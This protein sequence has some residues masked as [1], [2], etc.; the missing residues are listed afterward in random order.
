MIKTLLW[1]RCLAQLISVSVLFIL[2]GFSSVPVFAQEWESTDSMITQR[3]IHA[4]VLL[5]SGRVLAAGGRDYG[6]PLTAAEI[7][8]PAEPDGQ[9]WSFAAPLPTPHRRHGILLSTGKVLIVG[10]DPEPATAYLFD[11]NAGPQGAWTS[12]GN[13][14][15][16]ARY[17]AKL[18]ELPDGK[19][20]YS[21][22]YGGGSG[23]P[24]FSSAELYDPLTNIWSLTGSMALQR[25]SYTA[26]LLTVGPNAGKVLVA[27]GGIR[28]GLITHSSAEIY[29]PVTG[30]WAPAATMNSLRK[31]HTATLLPDGRVLV[32][33]GFI[34]PSSA[35][36]A[37]AEIYDPVNDTWTPAASMTTARA[38]HTAT[39]LLDGR[40]L[41][42]GGA[43]T[44]WSLVVG[45]A[46]IFDPVTEQWLDAGSMATPRVF[47][48]ATLLPSGEVLMTGGSN[49][50]SNAMASNEIFTP[51]VCVPPYSGL[52]SW[53]TL[54]ETSGP[55]AADIA[56]GND[57]T[58]V[59]GP[60]PASGMVDGALS[61]DGVDDVVRTPLIND[62]TNGITFSVWVKTTTTDLYDVIITNG[63][64]INSDEA[65]MGLLLNQGRVALGSGTGVH[66]VNNFAIYGPK[67]NDGLFHYVSGTWTGDTT[68][69]GANLYVD[70][71]LVGTA[72]A[73]ASVATSSPRGTDIGA[74]A[75]TTGTGAGLNLYNL[76]GLIDEVQIFNRVLTALEIEDVFSTEQCKTDLDGDGLIADNC[77]LIFNPSQADND[78]DGIGDVCD[79]DDD[80]DGTLDTSDNCPMVSNPDQTDNDLD[81]AGD[82]CDDDDDN[83]SVLDV[84]DNCPFNANIDQSDIDGDTLGDV[85]DDDPDGDGVIAGD[86]CP[87]N[88]NP[89]QE[90]NDSD[91]SG[92]ACDEDDDNDGV[93][94]TAD[95]CPTVANTNQ[96]DLDTDNIGDACDIDIDG[97]GV[98]NDLDNC[99]FIANIGQEDTD[100]DGEGDG[101]DADD[102]NDSI[103]DV[104]DN[105][106]L[107]VN[108]DQSDF[109]GDGQ[110]DVCDGDLDGDGVGNDVDNCISV[111][112]A[113]QYDWNNDGEGDVCD[114][115]VDGDGIV[116]GSDQC[117]FTQL[118]DIVDP[119][120]GCSIDQ[121]NPCDHPQGQSTPWKNHGQYVSSVTHTANSF[122]QQGLITQAERNIIVSNAANSTCGNK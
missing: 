18:I 72:T 16:L 25:V 118:G 51:S 91:G 1:R 90:D 37:T 12:T 80:N 60:I 89:L 32:S 114:D 59:N 122:V 99:P 78:A 9:K 56:G 106:P 86:N 23:S 76:E 3:Y 63:G 5:P 109:D 103:L 116:N 21:G 47:H 108:S 58:H 77:P 111:A 68:V 113:N 61:F 50:G 57:G 70:G 73:N 2:I 40:V 44:A 29:D 48:A 20:L 94:D 87:L 49:N 62:Y 27:G 31:Q 98:E 26:T 82:V 79:P 107:I 19:I 39:R 64:G 121:L 92:D 46:E 7:Y 117:E 22:G 13:Q 52:V 95:N 36:T 55:V 8:D 17:G 112:N 97:D 88:P 84:N 85:C 30:T 93:P 104:N 101:C 71:V 45:T 15:S 53:W 105:C 28:A 24:T 81:N 102:D 119:S 43:Q 65:G 74:Y 4:A 120:N 66:G 33:G 10:E 38:A 35:T 42:A 67:I 14:P 110:G 6:P 83:D 11:E 54:D 75:P 115:D 96:A 34:S 69:D 41:I 100:N